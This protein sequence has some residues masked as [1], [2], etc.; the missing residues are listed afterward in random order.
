LKSPAAAFSK[1]SEESIFRASSTCLQSSTVARHQD[2]HLFAGDAA[3]ASLA[4]ALARL[5]AQMA[6]AFFRLEQ[7][8]FIGLDDAIQVP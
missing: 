4:A 3:F 1:V 5:S 2:A 8:G 6:R 7:E